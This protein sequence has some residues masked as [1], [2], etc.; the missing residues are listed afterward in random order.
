MP[1]YSD[2]ILNFY[3]KFYMWQSAFEKK[4]FKSNDVLKQ[5][6]V[7]KNY[8]VDS[9]LKFPTKSI[10]RPMVFTEITRQRESLGRNKISEPMTKSAI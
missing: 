2:H 4:L 5:N 7:S 3:E 10:L 6:L 8:S 1:Y 9:G